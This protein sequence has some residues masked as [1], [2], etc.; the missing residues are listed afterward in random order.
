MS[1]MDKASK[2]MNLPPERQEGYLNRTWKKKLRWAMLVLCMFYV[3]S[4]NFCIDYPASLEQ[5][6]E[7]GFNISQGKYGLL[8]SYFALPNA[9]MPI[10]GGIFFDKLGIR[11][12]L[13]LFTSIVCLG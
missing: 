13:I 3:I 1:Q 10:V 6:I 9:I 12:G 2:V 8:Y 5:E 4:V 11:S 7:D